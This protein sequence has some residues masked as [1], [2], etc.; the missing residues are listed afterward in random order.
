LM[1]FERIAGE[2][3]IGWIYL[4]I[5]IAAFVYIRMMIYNGISFG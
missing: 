1:K 4:L 2:F 3:K 5:V